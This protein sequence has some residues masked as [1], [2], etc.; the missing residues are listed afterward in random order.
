MNLIERRME[1]F[2]QLQRDGVVNIKEFAEALGVSSMTIRRDLQYF[3]QQGIVTIS[4]GNAY[5]VP[6]MSSETIRLALNNEEN[7]DQKQR[8][9]REAAALVENGDAIIIDCGTTTLQLLRYLENKR[10]TVFTNSIPVAG[11]VGDMAN[12]KIVYA[13]GV[14][15]PQSVGMV[16]SLAADFFRSLRVDKSFLGALASFG[17]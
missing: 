8:I 17:L 4:T 13:P 15:S 14:F 2:R 11:L 1:V 12:I 3:A 9:G 6:G 5:L 7:A 16:G 10:V